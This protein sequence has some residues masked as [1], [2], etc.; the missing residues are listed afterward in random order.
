MSNGGYQAGSIYVDLIVRTT[1]TTK[2]IDEL[3]KKIQQLEKKEKTYLSQKK[4][5]QKTLEQERKLFGANSKQV[6]ATERKIQSLAAKERLLSNE[7]KL[8]N[9]ALQNQAN[10]VNN[11][12]KAF[13]SLITSANKA[14][15]TFRNLKSRIS[16]SYSGIAGLTTSLN[17][18]K[19][20]ILGVAAH[21]L[22][23]A[24]IIP[25]AEIEQTVTSLN[26]LLGSY[27]KAQKLTDNLVELAAKTP[28]VT[29]DLTQGAK[30]L[31]AA[32]VALED[33]EG[34]LEMLGDVAMGSSETFESLVSAYAKIQTSGR[35]QL[36]NIY[37]FTTA[38]VPLID[39]LVDSLNVSTEEFYKL[40]RAGQITS[41]D[42]EK[43]LT[44]LTE[45]GGRFADMMDRQSKTYTGLL[46][47]V[48][49][50][51]EILSQKIGKERVLWNALFFIK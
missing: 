3:S 24:L 36:R 28:L 39:A 17:T 48:K 51:F 34:T 11:Q 7:L 5:L 21:R 50:N 12:S 2:K 13:N 35:A 27:E 25:G 31:L 43:A 16:S 15:N 19:V 22:Y 37:S 4:V 14:A 9:K 20:A 6:Q 44:S 40:S 49:D 8:V 18:L 41:K 10:N 45:E 38:G 29:S 26:V 46:S 47:T 42:V 23:D 32:N 1:D 33:I 30:Q